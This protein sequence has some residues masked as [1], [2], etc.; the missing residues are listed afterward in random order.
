MFMSTS[1]ALLCPSRPPATFGSSA[2]LQQR[3]PAVRH[4]RRL[5][6]KQAGCTCEAAK[7]FAPSGKRGGKVE[8]KASD[9]TPTISSVVCVN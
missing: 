7:G 2:A 6:Q 1:I 4:E 9:A 3:Q 5:P 8:D